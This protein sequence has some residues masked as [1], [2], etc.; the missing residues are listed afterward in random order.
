MTDGQC[1]QLRRRS[2]PWDQAFP[3][4]RTSQVVNPSEPGHGI[5]GQRHMRLSSIDPPTS[6]VVRTS[7]QL[8]RTSVNGLA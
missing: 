1:K 8:V 4:D 6:A 3:G 5:H 7:L 2:E